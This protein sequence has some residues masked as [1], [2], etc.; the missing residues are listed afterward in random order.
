[1]IAAA[2]ACAAGLAGVSVPAF[3]STGHG[4]RPVLPVGGEVTS[5]AAYTIA[6]PRLVADGDVKGGRHVS[7]VVDI[8]I[9][10]GPAS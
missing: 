6:Q 1:M 8:Y 10:T 4:G 7:G 9:E 2:A 5:P 3:G